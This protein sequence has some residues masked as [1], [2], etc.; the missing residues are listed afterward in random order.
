MSFSKYNCPCFA[1]K[2]NFARLNL[3]SYEKLL[4]SVGLIVTMDVA[5]GDCGDSGDGG[6]LK[7]IIIPL[8]N[9]VVMIM[10]K[11]EETAKGF[12]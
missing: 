7:R 11:I 1:E 2:Y 8:I 12:W 9:S 3:S 5:I 10:Q 6:V 4:I